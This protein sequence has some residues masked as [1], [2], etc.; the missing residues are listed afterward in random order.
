M[1]DFTGN[2]ADSQISS[3]GKCT[4]PWEFVFRGQ[5]N[6]YAPGLARGAWANLKLHKIMTEADKVS[7][8]RIL[9]WKDCSFLTYRLRRKRLKL[10]FA[11]YLNVFNHGCYRSGNG[12]GK[13]FFKVR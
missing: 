8:L 12:H 6:A 2:Q 4:H 10:G 3:Y 9:K 5:K 1:E 11:L 13:K 7:F